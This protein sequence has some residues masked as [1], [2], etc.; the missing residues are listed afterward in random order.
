MNIKTNSIR[1]N[2]LQAFRQQ[3]NIKQQL[4]K[5][6]AEESAKIDEDG[7]F[8][9]QNTNTA[10]ANIDNDL[11]TAAK[12]ILSTNNFD[13]VT[14]E[15]YNPDVISN[16]LASYMSSTEIDVM[17]DYVDDGDISKSDV[18]DLLDKISSADEEAA[19]GIISEFFDGAELGTGVIFTV[20]T[21][22]YEEL[23][24]KEKKKKKTLALLQQLLEKFSKQNSAFLAEM[25]Q[26]KNHPQIKQSPKLAA[27][28]ANLS[29]GNITIDSLK[30]AISFVDKYLDADFKKIV[31]KCL[32]LRMHT[33]SRITK[34]KLTFEDKTELGG[35]VRC[36]KNLIVVNSIFNSFD[37]FRDEVKQNILADK[38][39]LGNNVEPLNSL[40][41]FA[42]NTMVNSFILK[43][44]LTGI[45][46]DKN[47]HSDLR[48]RS[49]IVELFQ[50]LP[51]ALFEDD[52]KK[53]QK[54]IE[55]LRTFKI[56]ASTEEK[57][58][59]SFIKQQKKLIKLV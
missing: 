53:R 8:S 58:T 11:E 52:N 16:L 25:F 55:G 22:L 7:L 14:A 12:Y 18:D 4:L 21:Y 23:A 41:E 47:F 19:T 49:K 10:N 45:G 54:L 32:R 36:E 56:N 30:K 29:A 42:E 3:Q 46:F 5:S 38:N 44:L 2:F 24:K 40:V 34:G 6:N 17:F 33:L 28:L 35:F 43:N 48:L 15:S 1:D 26:M 13:N 31:S 9:E 20:L 57:Q 51:M 59:F 27:G 50:H 39:L 37:K